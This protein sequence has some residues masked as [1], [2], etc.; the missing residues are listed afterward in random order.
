MATR[1][2]TSVCG[3]CELTPEITSVPTGEWLSLNVLTVLFVLPGKIETLP[4][5]SSKETLNLRDILAS[6]HSA[7]KLK[8]LL[9]IFTSRNIPS[10]GAQL[11]AFLRRSLPQLCGDV[12][13]EESASKK[14]RKHQEAVQER[15]LVVNAEERR[16][17]LPRACS[18]RNK[19]VEEDG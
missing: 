11:A 5:Q 12:M 1:L 19:E 3:C 16:A 4:E 15:R 13:G 6:L 17:V 18:T 7:Q 14:L 10:T 9:C 2:F 8:H